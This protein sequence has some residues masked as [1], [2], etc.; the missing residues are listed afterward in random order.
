MSE[1]CEVAKRFGLRTNLAVAV[2]CIIALATAIGSTLRAQALL[3]LV[4]IT[5]VLTVVVT[6][7]R[8]SRAKDVA[9][10]GKAI[11]Q[12]AWF[13]MSLSLSYIIMPGSPYFGM[14]TLSVAI[15]ALIGIVIFL[16]G[17]YTLLKTRKETGIMLSI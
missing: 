2:L 5:I 14:P 9:L 4:A 10:C 6:A 7:R 12:G 13:Y 16:I 8:V 11:I 17:I 3:G 15:D 1:K